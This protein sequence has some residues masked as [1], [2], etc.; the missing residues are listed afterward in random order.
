MWI[1]RISDE[2]GAG[3]W[4]V[5]MMKQLDNPGATEPT[6][7]VGSRGLGVRDLLA[8]SDRDPQKCP[9]TP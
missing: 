1:S 2:G 6:P 8:P 9:S 3:S 7:N 4:V 5:A